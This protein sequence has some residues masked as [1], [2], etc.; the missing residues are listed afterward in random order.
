MDG[1]SIISAIDAEI[2]TLQK[3]R[4]LLAGDG[5]LGVTVRKAVKKVSSKQPKRRT[6]SPE[7]RK[8][9]ADAQRKRWAAAK[10][11]KRTTPAKASKKAAKKTPAVKAKKAAPKKA[12]NAASAGVKPEA[13]KAEAPV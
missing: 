6:L 3:V 2:A 13:Q 12:A 7:A 9:I 8:R 1:Q 5:K 10:K 11:P 4:A